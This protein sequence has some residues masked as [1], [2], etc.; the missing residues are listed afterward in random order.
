M[1]RQQRRKQERLGKVVKDL[2]MKTLS[3]IGF[4]HKGA[5][6]TLQDADYISNLVNIFDDTLPHY[7][8]AIKEQGQSEIDF[9]FS[10]ID[11]VRFNYLDKNIEPPQEE[12]TIF[13]MNIY[14]LTKLGIIKDDAMNG[15]QYMYTR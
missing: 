6:I 8:K 15:L 5:G 9:Y 10:Q 3:F 2:G 1:T 14:A 13:M 4:Y 11:A 7:K 12:A